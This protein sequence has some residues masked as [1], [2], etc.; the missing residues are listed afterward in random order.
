MLF[1]LCVLL[2]SSVQT[3]KSTLRILGTVFTCTLCTTYACQYCVVL[4]SQAAISLRRVWLRETSMMHLLK[5]LK[6]ITI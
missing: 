5:Y 6:C 4:H 1:V 2:D 3:T